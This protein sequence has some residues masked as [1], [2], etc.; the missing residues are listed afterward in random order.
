[1]HAAAIPQNAPQ[2]LGQHLAQWREQS[3]HF[4]V[5]Y[6][7]KWKTLAF[8]D[9]SSGSQ[10]THYYQKP[11]ERLWTWSVYLF[12]LPRSAG[13]SKPGLMSWWQR[14]RGRWSLAPSE[15]PRSDWTVGQ[16]VNT[17]KQRSQGWGW[18]SRWDQVKMNME[19]G[20]DQAGSVCP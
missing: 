8:L 14:E 13:F 11:D 2:C 10:L 20:G 19:T 17:G 5:I 3:K 16:V 18:T 9:F 12:S 4:R 6:W 15:K 1:M 7:I